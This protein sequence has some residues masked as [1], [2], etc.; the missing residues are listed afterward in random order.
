MNNYLYMLITNGNSPHKHIWTNAGG[1]R[2]NRL[3]PGQCPCN[4]GSLVPPPF[5]GINY[6]NCESDI[7]FKYYHV[8]IFCTRVIFRGMESSVEHGAPR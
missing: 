1:E 2:Q 5:V 4:N 3:G 8:I 6:Y 7:Y